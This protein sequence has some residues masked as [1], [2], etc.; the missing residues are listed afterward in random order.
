MLISLFLLVF[1]S[2]S[3]IAHSAEPGLAISMSIIGGHDV[4]AP[5]E[6]IFIIS[7]IRN[8]DASGR[9]DVI[10]TYELLEGGTVLNTKTTTVAIETLSSFSEE[11]TLPGSVESGIYTVKATVTSLDKTTSSEAVNSIEVGRVAEESRLAV[12]YIMGLSF[13]GVLVALVYEHRRVSKMKIEKDDL[14][15]YVNV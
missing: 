8:N 1:I 6:S 10:V 13:A 2:T 11:F 12:E 14:K 4:F 5:G 7:E 15:K 9:I 3:F